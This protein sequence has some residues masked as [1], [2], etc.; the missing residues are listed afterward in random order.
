V[1]QYR[2]RGLNGDDRVFVRVIR[3]YWPVRVAFIEARWT[4]IQSFW[5]F[6]LTVR[7]LPATQDA[8]SS[9]LVSKSGAK[10]ES[11]AEPRQNGGFVVASVT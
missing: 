9:V 8:F 2:T 10:A 4:D 7:A 11:A 1:G 5:P 6:S 3:V